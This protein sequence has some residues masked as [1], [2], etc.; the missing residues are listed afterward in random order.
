[1]LEHVPEPQLAVKEMHRVLRKGG[2]IFAY[3]PFLHGCHGVQNYK[4]YYRFTRDGVE[5]KEDIH[6]YSTTFWPSIQR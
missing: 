6:E 1:M 2:K 3:V 5:Y 4:D